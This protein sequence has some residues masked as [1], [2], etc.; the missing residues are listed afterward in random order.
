[1]SAVLNV[2]QPQTQNIFLLCIFFKIPYD[3]NKLLMVQTAKNIYFMYK[4]KVGSLKGWVEERLIPLSQLAITV[5]PTFSR[6]PGRSITLTEASP[7]AER[8]GDHD[9]LHTKGC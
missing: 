1:M 3:L 4:L 7:N 9:P 6:Q 5:Q 2:L 8:S